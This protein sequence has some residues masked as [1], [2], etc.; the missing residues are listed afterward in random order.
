LLL[1]PYDAHD[2]AAIPEVDAIR[3]YIETAELQ[4]LGI[5]QE[6]IRPKT[7]HSPT[8]IAPIVKRGDC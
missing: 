5:G 6:I 3:P 1:A 2:A 8:P 4:G 7:T